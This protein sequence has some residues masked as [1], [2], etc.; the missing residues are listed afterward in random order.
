[1][2]YS[3]YYAHGHNAN[4]PEWDGREEPR[5]LSSTPI[6]IKVSQVIM[7]DIETQDH[8]R[9]IHSVQQKPLIRMVGWMGK[10]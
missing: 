8:D 6:E 5:L 9:K 1:L 7:K 10:K 2:K 4:G 3:Y